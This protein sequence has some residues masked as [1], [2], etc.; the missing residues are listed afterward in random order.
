MQ[1]TPS[2][3]HLP[4]RHSLPAQSSSYAQRRPYEQLLR[5]LLRLPSNP[6]VLM[7][8]VYPWWRSARDGIPEGLYYREPEIEKTVL[9]QVSCGLCAW[10]PAG[11][12]LWPRTASCP[13]P[14]S[15]HT[16]RAV[17]VALL[18][19]SPDNNKLLMCCF[20]LLQY[21]DVPVV[22]LRAA[23][24]R[25]MHEGI[26]GFKVRRQTKTGAQS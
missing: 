13:S 14:T 7:L 3:P 21:Y 19:S 10:P 20:L 5:S 25:L 16:N 17:H 9:A 11:E 26:E 1:F 23:A 4:H 24:W 22:S 6:A 18:H 8:Q 15:N 2:H 12:W